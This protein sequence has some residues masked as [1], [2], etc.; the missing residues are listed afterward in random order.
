MTEYEANGFVRVDMHLT[1]KT[2]MWCMWSPWRN[3]YYLR[4]LPI[5]F[6]DGEPHKFTDLA[7]ANAAFNYMESRA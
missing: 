7:Q 4:A 6:Q 3:E 2:S 5:N 1:D